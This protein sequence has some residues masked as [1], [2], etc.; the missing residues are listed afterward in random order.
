MAKNF[1]LNVKN[2]QLAAVLDK[3]KLKKPKKKAVS[4][5]PAEST[6]EVEKKE[7]PSIRITKR[8][9]DE[10]AKLD[11]L[12][13]EPKA[14]PKKE[15]KTPK[16]APKE[17]QV[18]PKEEVVPAESKDEPEPPAEEE[19]KP[20]EAPVKKK[21]TLLKEE[22]KGPIEKPQYRAKPKPVAPAPEKP[23][24]SAK[25]S[26]KSE[27]TDDKRKDKKKGKPVKAQEKTSSDK[28]GDNKT[29]SNTMGGYRRQA[30]SRVFDS[31]NKS[32]DGNSWKR[33]RHAKQRS[34]KSSEPVVRPSEITV[35]LPIGLKDL[36][37][38]MKIKS[39]EVIQKLFLQ[40]M[41]I[42]INDDL[43]DP[44]TV[45]LIGHEFECEI[46]IDTS[47]E[48]RLLVTDKSVEEEISEEEPGKLESRTPVVTVMG[49]VDHGKTS[50]ID[51][52]R[53]SNLTAGEAGAIT[54][55]IGA[56]VCHTAHGNFSVLDTPGHEAFGAIRSR[57]ANV[58][59][60][61]VLVIAGDEGMKP[62]TEEAIEAAQSANVPILVAINK[63]DK[64]GF[65]L[66]EIYRQLAD[67]SLLPEA[68]GGETITVACS[69]KS[70]EGIDQLAEMIAL[71]SEVLELKAN[72][73][74]RAR[75]TVLES[76]L[77][78]G[79]G[80]TATLLVQNGTLK[81]GDGI[82]FEYVSGR[83]KT[84][85][86][87][88]NHLLKE[89]GPSIPVK[90]TGL[91][92][93]PPAGNEFIVVENEKEARKLAEERRGAHKRQM[94]RQSRA[95]NMDT[96]FSQQ[97]EGLE[98]KVLNII[99]KADV[100]GSLEAVKASLLKIPTEKVTLNFVSTEVG[101]I[102]ESD[103]E[104]AEASKSIIIG[105]HANVESHA[106]SMVKN[107][108]IQIFLHDVIYHLID[109][110]K[111]VMQKLLDKVRTETEVAEAKVLTTFKS[112][113]LG[114]IAGCQVTDGIVKRSHYCK[115]ERDGEFIWEGNVGSLKRH[116]D[117]AKEV[118][119]DLECGILLQGF[120]KY[121]E[122]DIMHFFEIT[123][124]EQEL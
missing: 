102:S 31:R 98:K 104:L 92:G 117:D 108:K 59:D 68:W 55:H 89:A 17:K 80:S 57:G 122:D 106:E 73:N 5:E 11:A 21:N 120:T 12:K 35:Q 124:V 91:S 70:G 74:T 38:Q 41:A 114:L 54:Q 86:D 43:D 42:T 62:Q 34:K 18:E 7:K 16:E 3:N 44:T 51:S 67:K 69:A 82:L 4:K 10:M 113:Q 2:A 49:H 77:H 13:A 107:K 66:D 99:L 53:K 81:V 1:K 25:E 32:A 33:R 85:H 63:M 79:L 58:T 88:H 9:S 27:S 22:F 48:E 23:K 96:L 95:K 60:I 65:N 19:E 8:A 72:P 39:S 30:F 83:I 61:V 20:K 105:F 52:F 94:L 47:K 115:L 76:E 15:K 50:I 119:K 109:E 111:V 116:Q 110:V 93:V 56:F 75:G 14:E 28:S 71:Q 121:Q 29:K 97:K 100:G 46:K 118:K 6:E 84:M 90:I 37:A 101:Q 64:P 24:T 45:E 123:Y 36:A 112:S 40:G 103:I 26:A 78:K 87:E